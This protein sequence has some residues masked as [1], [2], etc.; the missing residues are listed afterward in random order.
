MEEVRRIRDELAARF[1][2]NIEVGQAG[3]GVGILRLRLATL[4]A[5]PEPEN[6]GC[7]AALIAGHFTLPFG[8]T[9]R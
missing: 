3:A 8:Y 2:H 5:P 6:P 1:D 7:P 9:L 4:G